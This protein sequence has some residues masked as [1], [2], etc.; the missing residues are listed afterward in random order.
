MQIGEGGGNNF[1]MT[2]ERTELDKK[3]KRP[4]GCARPLDLKI[5]AGDQIKPVDDLR[6]MSASD[7]NT[8]R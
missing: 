6:V 1:F 2:P 8:D 5:T 4:D 3:W 7:Y